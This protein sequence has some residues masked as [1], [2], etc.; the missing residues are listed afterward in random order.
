MATSE[1]KRRIAVCLF[2]QQTQ[3]VSF[4]FVRGERWKVT[5]IVCDESTKLYIQ[6]GERKYKYIKC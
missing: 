6:H 5:E 2:K 4:S 1:G 3:F